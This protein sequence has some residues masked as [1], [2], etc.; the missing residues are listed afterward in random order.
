MKEA[1]PMLVAEYTTAQEIIDEPM[2]AWWCPYVLRKRDGIIAGVKTQVLTKRFKN[3]FE[4]PATFARGI[5]I[6]EINVN[7]L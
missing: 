7:T 2:F 4:V 6:D 3:G 5:E 1:Y